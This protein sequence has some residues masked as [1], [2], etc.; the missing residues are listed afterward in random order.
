MVYN[1]TA[2]KRG[3]FLFEHFPE[4]SKL[5]LGRLAVP[6]VLYV[7]KIDSA[8]DCVNFN[9]IDAPSAQDNLT[10]LLTALSS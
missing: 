2:S 7:N 9:V 5:P 8:L 4:N 1:E 6:A 3:H 10:K